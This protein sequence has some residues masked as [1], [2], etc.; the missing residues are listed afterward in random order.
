MMPVRRVALA[1]FGLLLVCALATASW[2]GLRSAARLDARGR[3]DGFTSPIFGAQQLTVGVDAALEQYDARTLAAR[4]DLLR[5]AGVTTIRQEFR[6]ADIEPQRG[7]WRWEASDRIVREVRSRGMRLLPVLWTTP[8]WVRVDSG[9]AAAPSTATTP[10][11]DPAAFARFAA[12]FARRYGGEAFVAYQ[13][14]DEPNLSA[15][16]GDGLVNPTA[17]LQLLQA[18]GAAIRAEDADAVIALAALAPTIE[19]SA[20][21]LAPQVYLLKLYQLGGHQAF[22][23]A[24]AKPYG[25][26]LPPDDRRVDAGVLHFSHVILMREVMVAH[27]EGHK[28]IW[29]T[30]F[31]WNALPPGWGGEPSIWG[32]TTEGQQADYVRRAVQRAA[33]EWPWLGAMYLD[34]LEPRAR[35]EAPERDAR[36]GF[37]LLQPDGAPRPLLAALT[38]AVRAAS[39]APRAALFADCRRPQSLARTLRLENPMTAL[40]EVTSSAPD[41]RGPSPLA[42]FT[43]GWRFDQLGA[44]IPERP[45][46]KV[47]VRF[48][49]DSFA[50]LVRRANYRAYTYV[51]IDGA[52]ANRLPRDERGA[53]LI[54]TAPNLA[55]VIEIVEVARGLGPREHVAEITVDRGWNQW[56]LIGWSARAATA[57]ANYAAAQAAAAAIAVAALLGCVVLARRANLLA[58]LRAW[59]MPRAVLPHAVAAAIVLWATSGWTWATDAATAWRALG[60]PAHVLVGGAASALLFW[61]PA[62]VASIAALTVLTALVLLRAELGPVLAAFFVPFFLL[63][64]RIF[65]RSFPMV[66]ILVALS[67]ASWLLR[68]LRERRRPTLRANAIDVGVVV[69]LAAA[70]LST[71]QASEAVPAWRELRLVIVGPA[72]LYFLLR[73]MRANDETRRWVIGA[74]VAGATA[75]ALIGLLNYVR[76][77][78]FV[79]EFGLPRIKSIYGSANNDALYLARALPFAAAALAFAAVKRWQRAL[80]AVVCVVLLAALALTQSRGALLLGLPTAAVA[81]MIAA[82]GR[83]RAAG[84]AVAAVAALGL[85]TLVSGIA[86]PLVEG[87]RLATAFDLTRGTGF[88]RLNL[89]QSAWR[90]FVEHPWLGVGPDNFLYAYRSFYILPAAWQEPNLSHP[91]NF[92]LDWLTR[93]GVVGG[94]AG[95]ALIG[96]FAWRA[97]RALRQPGLRP[98]ALGC[99]GLLAEVLAHGMVDHS[100]FLVDLMYAF[101]IVAAL[102][103]ASTEE[104]VGAG[105]FGVSRRCVR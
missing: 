60:L 92:A 48:H 4:L 53:Y 34:G 20:V 55:P 40:P 87:T 51:T 19:Q 82:G 91:H 52:P 13:I 1:A 66:E 3:D 99:V 17:Y 63:P 2:F 103:A 9:S 65:E 101:M 37:A 49:G 79:A 38:D 69:M 73:V 59:R 50:L 78:R 100:F 31:G 94:A 14:W 96:G 61:S 7:V 76:G 90:M 23:V 56:A 18:A 88:F 83:W 29:A 25:F 102:L 95:A 47:T 8:A 16:W 26:D 84:I 45:D 97:R 70:M 64:Q 58:V 41:C 67:A 54:M 30:Q 12:A 32:N 68:A 24:A 72:A 89:W 42:T 44:D 36:W 27:G 22:D 46:A 62:A 71:L 80:L 21:N 74:F 104:P 15:A 81:M 5:D 11:R 39:A 75:I 98:F 28:A 6:W 105:D 77:D 35:A 43:D 10:P 33:Q 86:A 93:L 85:A 57:S